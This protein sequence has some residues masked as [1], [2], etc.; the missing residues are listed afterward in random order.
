MV[1]GIR[2]TILAFQGNMSVFGSTEAQMSKLRLRL[3][4]AGAA[5]TFEAQVTTAPNGGWRSRNF[6][7]LES[8]AQPKQPSS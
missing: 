3:K 4:E 7:F 5:E 1:K 2:L 8:D 6:K